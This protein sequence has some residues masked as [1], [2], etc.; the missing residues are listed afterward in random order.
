MIL[1]GA[2]DNKKYVYG[3]KVKVASVTD[4]GQSPNVSPG[5]KA[6]RKVLEVCVSIKLGANKPKESVNEHH[7]AW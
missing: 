2:N 1:P 6:R 3:S 5:Y 4:I 7:F